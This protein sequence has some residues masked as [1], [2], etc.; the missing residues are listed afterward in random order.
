MDPLSISSSP[1][2]YG[3]S[4][5]LRMPSLSSTPTRRSSQHPHPPSRADRRTRRNLGR[6]R[7]TTSAPAPPGRQ[8]RA[9]SSPGPRP[10]PSSTSTADAFSRRPTHAAIR[11]TD[12]CRARRG[13][14]QRSAIASRSLL[15]LLAAFP[16][17]SI[18]TF[19][20]PRR[21]RTVC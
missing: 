7:G 3:H 19:V 9:P 2:M 12:P 5:K 11:R 16:P 4:R 21:Q 10:Q 17:S 8:A 13:E 15:A 20:A 14:R 1:L 6:T 18:P